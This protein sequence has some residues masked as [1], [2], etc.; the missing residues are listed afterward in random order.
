[1]SFRDDERAERMC[2]ASEVLVISFLHKTWNSG[3]RILRYCFVHLV[4]ESNELLWASVASSVHILYF[5]IERAYVLR[6]IA[7]KS[8]D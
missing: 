5:V 8:S 2:K 3:S 6:V 7:S 1:M 4:I